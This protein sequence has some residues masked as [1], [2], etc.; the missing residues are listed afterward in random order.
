MKDQR[1]FLIVGYSFGS[2]IA[3]ELARLLEANDFSGRLILIDGAP[4]QMKTMVNQ[5]FYC[6]SL[7]ELQNTVLLGLLGMY[8]TINKETLGLELNKCNTVEE[9]LKIFHAYFPNDVNVLTIENQK[10]IYFTIY[11]HIVAIQDYDISS[12]P[13]LK[14]PITLL[15]PTFSSALYTE[16]DYGL[17]KVTEG[18][19]QIHYVEGN[20]ITMMDNDKI[21]SAINEE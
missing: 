20:H 4:D 7:E 6:A 2:L 3:I 15:K 21:I 12:L 16:E 18:K 5:Y 14:S 17:H 19:V 10:L 8:A 11:N 1:K 9:K 13:R